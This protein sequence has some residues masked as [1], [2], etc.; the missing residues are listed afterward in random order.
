MLVLRFGRGRRDHALF[1]RCGLFLLEL[2]F[3]GILRVFFLQVFFALVLVVIAVFAVILMHAGIR[4]RIS[5]REHAILRIARGVIILS[6][7]NMLS[8]RRG[9]LFRQIHVRMLVVMPAFLMLVKFRSITQFEI[10]AQRFHLIPITRILRRR[11]L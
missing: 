8:Q 10:R 6:V 2:G 11:L 1:F 4:S 3:F 9:F 5:R 7:R